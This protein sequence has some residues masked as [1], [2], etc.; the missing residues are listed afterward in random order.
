LRR[1]ELQIIWQEW[2]RGVSLL[3][4]CALLAAIY[5][6]G[7]VGEATFGMILCVTAVV[8]T[9][10]VV[11]IHCMSSM[12]ALPFRLAGSAV[13][14][15]GGILF[16][17]GAA[18]VLYPG[19]PAAVAQVSF[20]RP[21][22]RL[23]VPEG[24]QQGCF[25]SVRGRPGAS[26]T[27]QDSEVHATIHMKT[28]SA[29]ES[30]VVSLFKNRQK[31]AAGGR[32]S[33]G[34]SVS[35]READMWY[36]GAVVPGDAELELTALRPEQA[37]PLTLALHVPLLPPRSMALVIWGIVLV[38]LVLAVPALRQGHFPA[39]VPF[40]LSLAVVNELVLRGLPPDR[41]A[42]PL[43]GILLGG[44]FGGA[45]V[46]YG[47]TR[48]ARLGLDPSRRR[49]QAE[50]GPITPQATAPAGRPRQDSQ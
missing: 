17:A 46:G 22:A 10:A 50:P 32:S 21:Q 49:R 4:L 37:L 12:S 35:A 6:A 1:E 28:A 9:A 27:G 34:P 15:L 8:V 24:A 11:V 38:S 26:P 13:V 18:Q 5:F 36:L 39:V 19:Q 41:P 16:L 25:L 44:I 30:F 20:L 29:A 33:R 3:A 40:S 48:L 2:L 31:A 43:V 14:V 23:S 42:L 45:L 47:A 7:L